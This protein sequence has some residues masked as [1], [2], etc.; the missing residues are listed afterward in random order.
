[1]KSALNASTTQIETAK[2]M[3]ELTEAVRGIQN[4][5][6]REPG[7]NDRLAAIEP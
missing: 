2:L 4:A 7:R 5:I 3:A 1:M 6:P